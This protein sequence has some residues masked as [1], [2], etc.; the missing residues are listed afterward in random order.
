MCNSPLPPHSY[1]IPTSCLLHSYFVRHGQ[2][3]HHSPTSNWWPLNAP[4]VIAWPA[5]V[6]ICQ[7]S[8]QHVP[9]SRSEVNVF[10][11]FHNRIGT[12]LHRI[13]FAAGFRLSQVSSVGQCFVASTYYIDSALRLSCCARCRPRSL[14]PCR[15]ILR[16]AIGQ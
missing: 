7:H 3:G 4:F 5:V 1:P 8:F 13:P 15:T 2:C 16:Y 10:L 9:F 14:L 12:S 6:E 11:D